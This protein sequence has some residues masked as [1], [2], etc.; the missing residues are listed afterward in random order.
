MAK[1]RIIALE[2]HYLDPELA[3]RSRYGLSARLSD[4]SAVRLSEMDE[5]GI[6][7]QILSHAPPGLQAFSD[8]GAAVVAR[9]VNDR[10]HAIVAENPRRFA[11]FASLPTA[12]GDEAA[13]ELERC[14]ADLGF[15]GAMVH[16]LTAGIFLDDRRF[17]P[18]LA[19][20]AR[21]SV[22][23]Y[24]HPAEPLKVVQE[25]YFSPYIKSHPTFVRAAWGF[26]F[27]TGTQAIRLILSGAFDEYPS[28]QII[29]GHM[30]ETI[31]FLMT[32]IDE[33]LSRDTPMKDFRG[34]FSNHFSVTTSG[35]FSDAA[36]L[37]CMQELGADRIMFSVDW[38]FASNRAAV[39]WFA[40]TNVSVADRAKILHDN[41]EKMMR[42]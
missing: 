27:E 24:I 19:R 35:F 23:L 8:R 16:G 26:T 41:A 30:G 21:L 11:A 14:I 12:D 4:V 42:L 17:R 10:L 29:L 3:A 6:D 28:L 7:L 15:K 37:C 36:L 39:E 40:K 20:A 22:P 32:R 34:Y 38:P 33:A 2:E 1:Q 9:G 25:A 5:A 13:D 31:P 18:L